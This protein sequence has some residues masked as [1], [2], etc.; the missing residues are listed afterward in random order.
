[1][2]AFC[3]RI[4]RV[5][6]LLPPYSVVF[7]NSSFALRNYAFQIPRAD[8]LEEFYALAFDVLGVNDR[9]TPAALDELMQA[10]FP[11][12]QR[13]AAQVVAVQPQQVEGIEDGLALAG[14][15]FVELAEAVAIEADDFAVP[16]SVLGGQFIERL[17]QAI[18]GLEVIQIAGDQ[19]A[20]AGLDV[21]DRAEAVV[22]EFE[23]SSGS[24]KAL[25]ILVNRMGWMRGS[26]AH[27]TFS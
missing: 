4:L 24:S 22:F 13:Q 27:C 12:D 6:D 23:I 10:T 20:F 14:H 11:F 26:T 8:F 16:D 5:L 18:E 19:L 25:A 21:G 2:P 9:V 3:L 15:Q 17:L 1:V 7:V